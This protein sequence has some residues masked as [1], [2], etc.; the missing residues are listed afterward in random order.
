MPF[1]GSPEG[2]IGLVAVEAERGPRVARAQLNGKRVE[3]RVA[4][5]RRPCFDF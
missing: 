5:R 2:W 4:T 1:L 3:S